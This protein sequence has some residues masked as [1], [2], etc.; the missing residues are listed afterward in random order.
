MAIAV[1]TVTTENAD[2]YAPGALALGAGWHPLEIFGG[3]K[4]RWAKNDAVIYAAAVTPRA[5]KLSMTIEPGPGVDLRPFQLHVFGS[6]DAVLGHPT[7]LGKQ[8]ITIDLPPGARTVHAIRLHL[9][10][11]GKTV[12]N[13]SRVMDFRVFNIALAEQPGDV[14]PA[15]ARLGRGWHSLETYGGATFRWVGN[16]ATIAVSKQGE[17]R[18]RF[19]IEPGP[20][21]GSKPFVLKVS[22]DSQMLSEFPIEKRQTVIC[23]LPTV[24]AVLT[25]RV[26]GG[27]ATVPGDPRLMNFRVFEASDID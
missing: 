6:S 14:L 10:T 22:H 21:V 1:G 26:D 24:P 20:G 23:D 8:N 7:I 3:T 17:P 13:D 9:E 12:P 4:F 5:Y 19:D 2:I 15:W 27:D 18:L 16:D 25:L 11:G